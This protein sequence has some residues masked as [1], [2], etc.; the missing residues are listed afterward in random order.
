MPFVHVFLAAAYG[1][2][3]QSERARTELAEARKLGSTQLSVAKI[4]KSTWFENP[5]IRALS[6]DT[7]FVGLR[8][9]GMPEE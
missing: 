4:E 9:A 7:Y 8:K 3:G 6:E 5:K 1:L 2:R